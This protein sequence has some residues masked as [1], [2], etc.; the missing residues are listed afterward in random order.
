[1]SAL[2]PRRQQV[3][4]TIRLYLMDYGRS[5]TYREIGHALG[6]STTRAA[7]MVYELERQGLVRKR[8]F[9]IRGIEVLE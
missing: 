6:F 9:V 2:T 5:P 4:E 1:M 8:P 3:F 7:Q